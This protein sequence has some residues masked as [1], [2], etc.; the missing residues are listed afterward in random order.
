MCCGST[1]PDFSAQRSFFQSI[2][3][4]AVKVMT[5]CEQVEQVGEASAQHRRKQEKARPR[6]HSGRGRAPAGARTL[7]AKE[8]MWWM[9]SWQPH[10]SSQKISWT[11]SLI[12]SRKEIAEKTK[13]LPTAKR[14]P[15]GSRS[16]RGQRSV[17]AFGAPPGPLRRPS[18]RKRRGQR[19]YTHDYGD[20]PVDCVRDRQALMLREGV[21]GPLVAYD[22]RRRGGGA[23]GV[24]WLAVRIDVVVLRRGRARAQGCAG[25]GCSCR[26]TGGGWGDGGRPHQA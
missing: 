4:P 20:D 5:V 24:L 22:L 26:Q 3:N 8:R 2:R 10:S 16:V 21:D 15:V 13:I 19:K 23:Q 1:R 17:G 14:G 6:R 12:V 11:F 25:E 9:L 18:D 7:H